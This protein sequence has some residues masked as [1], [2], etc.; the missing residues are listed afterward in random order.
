MGAFDQRMPE[1]AVPEGLG[2]GP[3]EVTNSGWHK[4]PYAE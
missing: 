4:A 1:C 3:G 2:T